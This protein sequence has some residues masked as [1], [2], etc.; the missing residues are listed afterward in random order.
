MSN[1]DKICRKCGKRIGE[2][3]PTGGRSSL[4]TRDSISY[5]C[6]RPSL[7]NDQTFE[8]NGLYKKNQIPYPTTRDPNKAFLRRKQF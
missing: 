3:Y 5:L 1:S 6:Y 2:H 7:H 4:P 8:W